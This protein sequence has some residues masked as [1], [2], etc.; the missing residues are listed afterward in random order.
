MVSFSLLSVINSGYLALHSMFEGDW[1]SDPFRAIVEIARITS[2]KLIKNMGSHYSNL[3]SIPNP[4]QVHNVYLIR[5]RIAIY[6]F[7]AHLKDKECV[8]ML[9]MKYSTTLQE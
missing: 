4:H 1:F 5:Y 3:I 6:W 8:L 9:N 7:L 2:K